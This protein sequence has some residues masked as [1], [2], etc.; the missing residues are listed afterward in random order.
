MSEA[1]TPHIH[2]ACAIIEREGRVLAAQRSRSMSMPLK[3]EFPGGK[4]EA[5]ESPKACLERELAEEMGVGVAIQRVM[6][7]CVHRYPTFTITLY[8]FVCTIVSGE[9][10]LNEHRAIAWLTPEEMT[11]LTWTA[12]DAPIIEAYR[13]ELRGFP[14]SSDRTLPDGIR[15]ARN[16]N[17]PVGPN[18]RAKGLPW[19]ASPGRVRDSS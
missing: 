14:I 6:L 10:T 2:V 18:G 1:T 8:P 7:P 9:I 3:W 12:A 19:V 4:I 17:S 13:R 5:G 15:S 16:G 11:A